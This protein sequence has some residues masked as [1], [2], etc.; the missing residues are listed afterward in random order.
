MPEGDVLVHTGDFCGHGAL[1]EVERFTKWLAK[2]DYKRKIIVAG[3]HEVCMSPE[4]EHSKWGMDYVP[5]FPMEAIKLIENAGG[6][7]LQDSSTVV[8]MGGESV[9][10]YGAPWQPIIR[11]VM[12]EWG[13]NTRTR[14]QAQEKWDLIESDTDVLLTHGPPL[15][16][17][18]YADHPHNKGSLGCP[19]LLEAVKRIK[20]K[21]HV[22]GHIHGSHGQVN[23]EDTCFI[24]AA[25]CTEQYKPLNRP[26]VFDIID[27]VVKM[28]VA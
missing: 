23:I 1:K 8:E 3:N 19:D 15:D 7:Y 6:I 18:D 24:N 21:V 14:A 11:G 22:F 13:F 12:R 27:G 5:R 25:I 10:F 9:K 4:H 20:P 16:I 28:A 2:Q 26:I 17:L